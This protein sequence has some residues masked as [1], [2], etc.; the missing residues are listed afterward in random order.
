MSQTSPSSVLR[1]GR[2]LLG[3]A[4]SMCGGKNLEASPSSVCSNSPPASRTPGEHSLQSP[5]VP[6]FLG[7]WGVRGRSC[8]GPVPR[9]APGRRFWW[10]RWRCARPRPEGRGPKAAQAGPAR[11]GVGRL[12]QGEDGRGAPGR[13]QRGCE[14]IGRRPIRRCRLQVPH[15]L[16]PWL[17][18]LVWSVEQFAYFLEEPSEALQP[19]LGLAERDP[20]PR[21]FSRIGMKAPLF[22]SE[23]V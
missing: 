17:V 11:A 6:R 7:G 8:A 9:P 13:E 3:R 10:L 16:D 14:E 23:C 5:P 20:R 4:L 12:G 18:F 1:K 19:A 22:F 21:W 2:L 15:P